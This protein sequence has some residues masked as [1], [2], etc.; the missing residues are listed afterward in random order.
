ME[1]LIGLGV[2]IGVL[3]TAYLIGWG[4][5]TL[6]DIYYKYRVKKN[7]INHPKLIELQKEREKVCEE[8]NRWWDEKYEAQKRIDKNF[9]IMKY[10]TEVGKKKHL[11]FIEQDQQIYTNADTHM[12]ELH[13]LVDTAREAEQTYREKHHIRHW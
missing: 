4:I 9:E 6:Y 1:G 8:Y 2:V 13:P 10:C 7:H 11:V 12:K 3:G 5:G